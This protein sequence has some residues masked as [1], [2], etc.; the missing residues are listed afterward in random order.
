M[1]FA[2]PVAYE[3]FRMG[4]YG[5][6]VPN[7]AIA[8]EASRAAWT[9]GW[10]YL[11]ESTLPY[12][13]WLP[14]GA[15]LLGGYLPLAR[16]AHER[17][18]WRPLAV[19]AA[20]G[21]GGLLHALFV[22]RV[23]G[24]FMHA[25]LLLPSIF[26]VVAPVA[27]VAVR[28]PSLPALVVLPWAVVAAV[29]L[30]ASAD[31]VRILGQDERNLVTVEDFGWQRGGPNRAW[32]RGDGA[33]FGYTRLAA[34][35]NPAH[36][37]VIVA[38][39]G[40]GISGYAMPRDVYVLDLLGLADVLTAHLRLNQQAASSAARKPLPA[41]S[42]AARLTAPGSTVAEEQVPLPTRFG[43]RA[44]DDPDRAPVPGAGGRGPRGAAVPE[45]RDLLSAGSGRLTGRRVLE[46]LVDAVH[47][48]TLRIP[49]EP[50]DAR[51]ALCDEG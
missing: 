16:A 32:F 15:L 47:N 39:F 51:A 24:D 1:A 14:L 12:W 29:A 45:V 11:R 22:T 33:Y 10:R 43:V 50:E 42:I 4:Y 6:L 19:L 44:L 37:D 46:N 28:R 38:T 49:P 21:I 8:K 17:R 31:D 34:A 3:V 13:L 48:T 41:P 5:A 25:R 36:G 7:P 27:A 23:G 35:P 20:F 9:S 2:L 18:A 26:A 40:L 30:R